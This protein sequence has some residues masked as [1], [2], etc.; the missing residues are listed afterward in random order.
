[1]YLNA[2]N[3][4]LIPREGFLS[5]NNLHQ[6]LFVVDRFWACLCR[7]VYKAFALFLSSSCVSCFSMSNST[8]LRFHVF[9]VDWVST[10]VRFCTF[11]C[12]Y[13]RFSCLHVDRFMQ[14]WSNIQSR[15]SILMYIQSRCI[16]YDLQKDIRY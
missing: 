11:L 2:F 7:Q 10:G 8:G 12:R 13:W 5:V 1:M 9:Y 4:D 16:F 15:Y 14:L 3:N 6:P